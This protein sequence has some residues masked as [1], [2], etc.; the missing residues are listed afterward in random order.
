[1]TP[2][3]TVTRPDNTGGT[4]MTSPDAQMGKEITVIRGT[5]K[6]RVIV[7]QR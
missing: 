5:E 7:P 6:T 4:G 2:P 1:M 3:T